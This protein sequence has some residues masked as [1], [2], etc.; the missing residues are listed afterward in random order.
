MSTRIFGMT[1]RLLYN[2][3]LWLAR[4]RQVELADQAPPG[5]SCW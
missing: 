1:F 2:N 4:N 3:R 5:N